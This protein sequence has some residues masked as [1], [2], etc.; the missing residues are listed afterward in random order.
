M[1]E[2]NYLTAERLDELKKELDH[3]KKV[4]RHEI[5]AKITEAKAMGDLSENAAY[6]DAKEQQAFAE[7]HI[8][9]LEDFLKTAVVI[10]KKSGDLVRIGS[11]I[12]IEGNGKVKNYQIVGS[13]EANPLKGMISN[14]SP[15]GRAFLGHK[16]GDDVVVETPAGR[17]TYKITAVN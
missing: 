1:A 12:Q 4:V 7:G 2:K 15:I 11:S 13:N 17:A 14:E 9:E 10:Q 8:L 3:L 6:S 5:I 16:L